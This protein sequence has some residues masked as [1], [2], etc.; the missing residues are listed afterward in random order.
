MS[1][2]RF[3]RSTATALRLG[4]AYSL[5]FMTAGLSTTC[6][7]DAARPQ[8]TAASLYPG[9]YQVTNRICENPSGLPDDCP[10]IQYLELVKGRFHGVAP[11]QMAFVIWLAPTPTAKSYTY[12]AR[13]LRGSFPTLNEYLVDETPKGREWLTLNGR[14]IREYASTSF[15]GNDGVPSRRMSL[16]L[17]PVARTKVLDR[18]LAYP[19][20]E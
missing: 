13:R 2:L 6:L 17:K 9:L 18:R 8:P 1:H 11:D 5:F 15:M 4:A 12:N 10:R 20:P 3:A 7:S 14:I 16:T 19:E